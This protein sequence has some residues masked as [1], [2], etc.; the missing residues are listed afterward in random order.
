MY[1]VVLWDWVI[2]LPREWRF[3]WKTNWTP[4]KVAYLFCRCALISWLLF[5]NLS[6][7][8]DESLPLDQLLGDSSG[9]LPTLLFRDGPFA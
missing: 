1:A 3:I 7:L 2:S 6:I 8:T 9:S 5:T 4:V